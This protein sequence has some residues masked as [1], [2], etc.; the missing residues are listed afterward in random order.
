ML[1]I[2]VNNLEFSVD[3]DCNLLQLISVAGFAEQRIALALNGEFVAKA[4]YSTTQLSQRDNVD[5]VKP[6]GGG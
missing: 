1:N 4:Q 5:I 6:I 3:E 2:S